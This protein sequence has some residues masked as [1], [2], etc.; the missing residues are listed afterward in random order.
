MD[1][2]A[3]ENGNNLNYTRFVSSMCEQ[4]EAYLQ[5]EFPYLI[6]YE[7]DLK[8]IFREML[9]I[10]EINVFFD[11]ELNRN[12][13]DIDFY[14]NFSDFN[15]KEDPDKIK[16]LVQ[17][18][19]EILRSNDTNIDVDFKTIEQ[20]INFP[21]NFKGPN[22][23]KLFRQNKRWRRSHQREFQRCRGSI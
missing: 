14:I 4:F 21:Y 3:L 11:F 2:Q 23:S 12:L 16:S 20:V 9:E 15:A 18:S 19:L 22:S 6:K 13:N 1:I 5:K 10:E 8:Q 7:E 17:E